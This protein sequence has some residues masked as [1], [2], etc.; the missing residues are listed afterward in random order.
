MCKVLPTDIATFGSL[1]IEGC[2]LCSRKK[3]L[4]KDKYS[5][6][7]SVDEKDIIQKTIEK[8]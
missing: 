5:L 3:G 7:K 2:T 4:V 8:K 6:K 1:T